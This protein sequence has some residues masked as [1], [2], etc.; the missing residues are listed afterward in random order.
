MDDNMQMKPM[1]LV[2]LSKLQADIS[3]NKSSI[4]NAAHKKIA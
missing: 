1:K 3:K 4:F 2:S